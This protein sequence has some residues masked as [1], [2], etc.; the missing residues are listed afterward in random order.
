MSTA[1]KSTEAHAAVGKE[2]VEAAA[3]GYKDAVS[4]TREQVEK[5]S[6]YAF[7]GYDELADFQRETF[8]ALMTSSNAVTKGV[9]DLGREVATYTQSTVELGFN[10]ARRMFDAKTVNEV[11][12]LH[13]DWA[14]KSFDNMLAESTKLQELSFQVA[15]DAF[16]PL[17][18]H[19]ATAWERV[20][21]PTGL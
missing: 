13:N 16:E 6:A 7:K 1:K 5:A 3:K 4:M 19:A 21:K 10:A 11:I 8:D 17:N 15:K 18:A 9:E 12:D 2:A 14:K 20:S